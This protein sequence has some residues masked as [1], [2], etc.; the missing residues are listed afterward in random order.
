MQVAAAR[1]PQVLVAMHALVV[2]PCGMLATSEGLP[3]SFVP[4]VPFRGVHVEVLAAM[5][6]ARAAQLS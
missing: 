3:V 5:S 2:V 1:R 6:R 4:R